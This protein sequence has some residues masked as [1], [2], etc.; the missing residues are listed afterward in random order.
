MRIS[1]WS[2]DV[3]SSDLSLGVEQRE[4]HALFAV[5]GAGG[6]AGGRADAAVLLGNQGRVVERLVRIE[7]PELL[8]HAPVQVLGQ[9]LGQAVAI[10]SASCR[11]RGC[12]SV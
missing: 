3:C 8:A 12:Q 6:I 2:S 1:D 7:P 9:G 11:E 5:L 4:Q 10:G